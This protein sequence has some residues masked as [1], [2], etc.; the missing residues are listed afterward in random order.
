MFTNQA[1]DDA[2]YFI[3]HDALKYKNSLMK[4]YLQKINDLMNVLPQ[5]DTDSYEDEHEIC[6]SAQTLKAVI[7]EILTLLD[8]IKEP[9]EDA[10]ERFPERFKWPKPSTQ[11][12][13]PTPGKAALSIAQPLLSEDS[14]SSDAR[15]GIPT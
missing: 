9:L 11:E 1:L 4:S 7:D 13:T 14:T 10:A 3:I 2:T 6:I 8:H 5:D 12:Q 15:T